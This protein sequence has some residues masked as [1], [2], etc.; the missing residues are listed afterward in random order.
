MKQ[1]YVCDQLNHAFPMA[2]GYEAFEPTA[3]GGA[4]FTNPMEYY[5]SISAFEVYWWDNGFVVDAQSASGDSKKWFASL[6]AT[7]PTLER[8]GRLQRRKT[9]EQRIME[10]LAE[11]KEEIAKLNSELA[12]LQRELSFYQ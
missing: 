7:F 5:D 10:Q 4:R 1:N 2:Q 12:D 9:P 8:I 11:V 6:E 3:V